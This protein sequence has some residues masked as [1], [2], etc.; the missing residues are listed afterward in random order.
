MLN[1]F[2]INLDTATKR[3]CAI[4]TNLEQFK[5]EGIELHRVCAFDGE[6]VDKNQVP[7]IIR[8]REK[9][10]FLSHIKAIEA[11]LNYP[12]YAL[13]LEDD[14]LLGHQSISMLKNL[15]T[16]QTSDIDLLF[17][18]M[19]ISTLPSMF[20]LYKLKKELQKKSKIEILR[21]K[22]FDFA[23]ASAYLLNDKSKRKLL[24]ILRQIPSFDMPYDLVLKK[25]I[26]EDEIS[27][28]FTFPFIATLGDE[29]LNTSIQLDS[30]TL[31]NIVYDAFRKLMFIE[32]DYAKLNSLQA[33]PRDFYGEDDLVFGKIISTAVSEKFPLPMF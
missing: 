6:F 31:Q 24:A 23:G 27:S 12:G 5:S 1:I 20:Q 21:T 7:G 13:I 9:G 29:S 17:I 28:G 22:F 2:Y 8:S 32:A 19:C 4:E 30:D 15:L 25:L 33:I 14:I 11:S 16:P 26:V 10:C 18:E 3:R